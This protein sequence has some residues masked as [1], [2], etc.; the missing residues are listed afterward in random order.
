MPFNLVI[1]G[2][3]IGKDIELYFIILPIKVDILHVSV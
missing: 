1:I 2:K 3:D